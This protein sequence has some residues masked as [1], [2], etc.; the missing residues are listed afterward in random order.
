[1]NSQKINLIGLSFWNNDNGRITG[2]SNIS[3]SLGK[4]RNTVGSTSRIYKHCSTHSSDPL[5]CSV[6]IHMNNELANRVLISP[7]ITDVLFKTTDTIT[8][9]FTQETNKITITNYKYSIDGG[10]TYTDFSPV[11]TR[12][13]VTITGL[14][15]NTTYNISIK[16]V[17]SFGESHKSNI[18]TETTYT[19]VNYA[20]F[21]DVGTTTWTVP[22]N[23]T[24][25]QYLVV[26]GGGGG[27]STY[28][29]IVTLGNVDVT[30]IPQL[31]KFW[32][33]SANLTNGRYSGRMYYGNNTGQNSALFTEPV[34]IIASQNFIP[35]GTE[36]LY[37]RWYNTEL[38]YILNSALVTTT[39][40]FSPF[41]INSN[42]CN[43]ISGGSGG[44]AGGQ[45]KI[46]TGTNK[47]IVTPGTTYTIVIGQ[48]GKGGTSNFNLENNGDAG[49]DSSFGTIVSIGGSGGSKSR[50]LNL[51]QDTNKNGKGGNGG[52]GYGNLFGGSGGGLT[53][54][55]NYGLYNSGGSGFAGYYINFDGSNAKFYGGGGNGGVPNTIATGT[56]INGVGR[57]GSGTG[58]RINYYANGI[59]GG[60]GIVIIKY[61]T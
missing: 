53:N 33:N 8:L 48:G 6:G 58:S 15:S 28:S 12:S 30:D 61:Y 57:G 45:V 49:G 50:N 35:N 27:G 55:N 25:V 26:G 41:D 11:V 47:Y 36:Y 59:D 42:R 16:A 10:D 4:M 19:N 38:V 37:N 23:V 31:D 3:Y 32:I 21:T 39:N 22:D 7:V 18:I 13:P 9:T 60:S 29:N 51:N 44:G 56:T 14:S 17:S 20:T 54:T 2:K 34:Q 46:L 52:Q 40:Y 1:M 43:N 5:Y 24:F